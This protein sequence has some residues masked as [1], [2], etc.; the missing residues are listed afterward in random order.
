M[1]AGCGTSRTAVPN[2]AVPA[3]PSGYT[4]AGFPA[5]G[6]RFS[7]PSNWT[8]L[9]FGLPL[10]A[11]ISS[12]PA[13][14]A[15]WRFA[16][17]GPQPSDRLQLAQARNRLISA[18]RTRDRSLVVIRSKLT[19]IDGAPT[20]VLDATE[21]NSG[22]PQRVRSIH[23]FVRGGEIVLDEYAPPNQF[24]TV[25]HDVFSPLNHSVVLPGTRASRA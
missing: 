15:L 7:F 20:I 24:H 11:T 5:V 13:V 14:V 2:A 9:G 21:T 22:R 19:R 18:A 6:I 17:S 8:R 1:I 23:I 3:V 16:R 12:G 10:D 4:G 25:D